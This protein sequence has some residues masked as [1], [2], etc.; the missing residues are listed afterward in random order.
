MTDKELLK[1]K[2]LQKAKKPKFVRQEAHRRKRLGE[3][4]RRPRGIHSKM[5]IR[6]AGKPARVAIGYGSP[7]KLRG[8]LIKK[9]PGKRPVLVYNLQELENLDPAKHVAIIGRTVGLKKKIELIKKA[10]E[11]KIIIANLEPA[12]IK[13]TVEAKTKKKKEGKK[14]K[15]KEK[16]KGKSK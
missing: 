8:V 7:A 15:V 11:K 16:T 12:K 13:Q 10:E 9:W 3:S 6:K 2:A 4:W 14:G 1:Q 5:R